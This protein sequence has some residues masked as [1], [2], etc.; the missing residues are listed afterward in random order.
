MRKVS[1]TNQG[2]VHSLVSKGIGEVTVMFERE[3]KGPCSCEQ[4]L[5]VLVY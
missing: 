1:E 5:R 4:M 3:R 2:S